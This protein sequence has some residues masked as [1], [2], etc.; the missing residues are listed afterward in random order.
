MTVK[1]S[2]TIAIFFASLRLNIENIM[3]NVLIIGLSGRMGGLLKE[4]AE[5]NGHTVIGGITG[6][7]N[8]LTTTSPDIII[9]FSTPEALMSVLPEIANRKIPLIVG[10]TGCS[11]N[12]LNQLKMVS[13]TSPVMYSTN[14]SIG[15]NVLFNLV[16]L[17]AFQLKNKSEVEIVEKHHRYKKDAPSGTAVTLGEI[18]SKENNSSLSELQMNGRSGNENLRKDEIAFHAL[19]GGNIVGDHSVQFILDNEIIDIRHEAL[20]R[21]IFADGAVSAIPFLLEKK[22]GFYHISDSLN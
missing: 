1:N 17:A 16:K 6:K 12:E 3:A 20:N 18:I 13:E 5:E 2:A 19:R 9:D 4:A 21:K 22:S 11:E 7:S 15:V 8:D 14:Y 10:T